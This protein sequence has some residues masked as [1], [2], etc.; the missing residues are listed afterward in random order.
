ML[1]SD[2]ADLD[3][4]RVRLDGVAFDALTEAEV[5]ARVV[6]RSVAGDGGFLLTPNVD[7][8]RQLRRPAL[9]PLAAA[10]DLVVADGMPL[11]WA[12]RLLGDPLPERVTG[13]ALIWSISREA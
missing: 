3:R 9:A 1:T 12:S 13:A 2:N 4:H 10:A 6:A 8:L 7:I 5:A 11:I